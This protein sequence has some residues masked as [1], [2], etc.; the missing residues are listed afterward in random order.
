MIVTSPIEL[1]MDDCFLLLPNLMHHAKTYLKLE[2]HSLTGSIKIKAAVSMLTKLERD[3]RL[4]PGGA[5]IESSS[6]NLGLAL[7]MACAVKGYRFTCVSDP[8][9]SPLTAKMI[10]AYGAELIVVDSRDSNG[11][12]LGVRLERIKDMMVKDPKLVWTNQY[13]NFQNVK[14]HYET[15][16]TRILEALKSVDFVFV[17]AGTTG[18][19][20]GVSQYIRRNSPKTKII[21]VDSVGSVTF[22]FPAS[23]RHIPGLGTSHPPKIKSESEFD[24]L[25]L[26]EE[27]HTI[28]TCHYLARRGLL[29]GGSTGTVVCAVH[30]YSN[31]IPSGATVAAIS[32]DFGD[33]YIDTIYDLDW[34]RERFPNILVESLGVSMPSVE[35]RPPSCVMITN[36][37]SRMEGVSV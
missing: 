16:G 24:D 12:Y 6:G 28:Q 26:I 4:S 7:A 8:N 37:S 19:L 20:G 14:A 36:K 3:G 17:G 13:E 23:K 29:I 9:I 25:I 22:G 31:R 1:I 35:M 34:I 33:R 2:G 32:P 27:S 11:G 21:A 30:H 18:T 15:T 10:R 5:V